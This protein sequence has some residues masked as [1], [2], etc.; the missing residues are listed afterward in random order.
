MKTKLLALAGLTATTLLTGCLTDSDKSDNNSTKNNASVAVFT[1]DFT[2]GALRWIIGDSL[3][4]GKLD[5]YQDAHIRAEGKYVYILE[6]LGGDNVVKIDASLLGQGSE[7]VLYQTHLGDGRN[8][9]DLAIVSETKGWIASS[10]SFQLL[11]FNPTTGSLTDSVDL[12]AFAATDSATSINPNSLALVGDTLCVIAQRLVGFSPNLPGLV[13][14]LNANTGKLIDTLQLKGHN[15]SGIAQ[16]GSK[17]WIANTGDLMNSALDATKGI[18][19]VDLSKGTVK[20]LTTGKT[21]QG[22]ASGITL[23]SAAGTLYVGVYKGWGAEPVASVTVSNGAVVIDSIPGVVN[24]FGGVAFDSKSSLLYIGEQDTELAGVKTW[25]G[26]SLA[27][28]T[29]KG[30]LPPTSFAIATW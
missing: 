24:A 26:D 11:A 21:L 2:S 1:S 23:D 4:S 27:T 3:A 22:G 16:Q 28:I 8:P 29:S 20:T 5:F 18:D 7:A 15:P 25:N 30:A 17:L 9:E 6:R 12:S 14:L 13:I 10:G 19:E